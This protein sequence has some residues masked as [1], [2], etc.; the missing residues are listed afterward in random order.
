MIVTPTALPGVST[1]DL[2]PKGDARGFFARVFCAEGFAQAGLSERIVQVNTSVT[3][4]RHT[5]RGLHYQLGDAAEDKTIKVL[6]GAI[7]DIVLDLRAGP[8]F[9]RWITVRLDDRERRM[10][11]VPKGCAHGF[12]TL[13]DDVEMLYLVSAAYDACAERTV[14]WDDPAFGIVLPARPV[15]VSDKDRAAPDFDPVWHLGRR[16]VHECGS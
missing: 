8:T 1:I 7:L 2:A 15:V 16:E 13:G 4:R 6:R 10:L 14:R 3:A 5:L 11:H 9:G 12:L